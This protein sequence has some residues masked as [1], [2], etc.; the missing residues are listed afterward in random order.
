ME[1]ATD[2]AETAA[3]DGLVLSWSEN[4][5][6]WFCLRA[7][8]Y[9]LNLMSSRSS[10]RGCNTG[11]SVTVLSPNFTICAYFNLLDIPVNFRDDSF[12]GRQ[13]I[14]WNVVYW[15]ELEVLPKSGFRGVKEGLD[16]GNLA[17]QISRR[18]QISDPSSKLVEDWTN[19]VF[20]VMDETFVRIHKRTHRH[21]FKWFYI[22]PIPWTALDR[23]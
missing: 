16:P 11:A 7:P 23:Q 2:R 1:Q 9:G 17:A 13:E 5:S 12:V 18:R 3:I 15:L 4:I 10:S 8:G 21:T 20:A 22:C 19:I 14:R 6:V